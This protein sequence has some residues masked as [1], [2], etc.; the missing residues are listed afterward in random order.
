[1]KKLFL[2]SA[3]V[4]TVISAC[5]KEVEV[6]DRAGILQK[7]QNLDAEDEVQDI[8]IER[9]TTTLPQE[10]GG[11]TIVAN[12]MREGI[13]EELPAGDIEGIIGIEDY[14]EVFALVANKMINGGDTT[15]I[16]EGMGAFIISDME[17]MITS[18]SD[19]DDIVGAIY[20]QGSDE[21]MVG[22]AIVPGMNESIMVFAAGTEVSN[23]PTLGEFNYEGANF[24]AI[25]DQADEEIDGDYGSFNATVDFAAGKG[26][27]NSGFG[28]DPFYIDGD[29]TVDTATGIF[30][31]DDLELIV[32]DQLADTVTIHG[33]FHGAGAAGM[34]GI[35][36]P[37]VAEPNF[38]GAIAG[39]QVL[40]VVD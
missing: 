23:I 7:F 13:S 25:S 34:T 17:A 19:D 5:T 9:L 28:N 16:G 2:A 12:V 3:S 26:S 11:Q 10:L 4:L 35:Y 38:I 8:G 6:A 27:I 15:Q 30:V 37:N 33:N 24:I 14:V 40:D 36:T 18:D 39:T 31:G 1:M 32:E 29:F 21:D 22:V 20:T